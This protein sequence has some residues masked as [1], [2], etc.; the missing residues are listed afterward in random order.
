MLI[1]RVVFNNALLKSHNY[2]IELVLS[3]GSGDLQVL[4]VR[5]DLKMGAGKIASQCARK[6]IFK[7]THAVLFLDAPLFDHP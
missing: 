4:V 3:N 2:R 1:F 7:W 6:F 5:Q